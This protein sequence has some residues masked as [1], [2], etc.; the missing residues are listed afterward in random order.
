MRR[1]LVEWARDAAR[2]SNEALSR[3]R[4]VAQEKCDELRVALRWEQDSKVTVD[5][6]ARQLS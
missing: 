1:R 2:E 3:E 4:D 6:D 5:E